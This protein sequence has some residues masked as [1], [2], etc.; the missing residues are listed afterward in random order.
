M[1]AIGLM[2]IDSRLKKDDPVEIE[3]RGNRAD[4]VVVRSHLRSVAPPYAMPVL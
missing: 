2:L 3:I 1:R 4:A